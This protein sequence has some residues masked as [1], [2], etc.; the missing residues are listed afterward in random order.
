MFPSVRFPHIAI[1]FYSFFSLK[2]VATFDLPMRLS[3]Y[4]A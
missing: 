4:I 3:H 1:T 2:H